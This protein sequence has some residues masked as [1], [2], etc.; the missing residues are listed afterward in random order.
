MN[1][2]HSHIIA[3]PFHAIFCHIANK[4]HVFDKHMPPEIDSSYRAAHNK[5]SKTNIDGTVRAESDMRSIEKM[6][7]MHYVPVNSASCFTKPHDN[8]FLQVGRG[9]I[10]WY[11]STS[12][13]N[14]AIKIRKVASA[15][16]ACPQ[17]ILIMGLSDWSYPKIQSALAV[18]GMYVCLIGTDSKLFER[19]F[20]SNNCF[21][22]FQTNFQVI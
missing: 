3:Y 18:V 8:S 2:P 16:N 19:C 21:K 4:N 20:P 22:S 12:F 5:L 7:A 11:A 17:G 6:F 13:S 10:T 9:Q 15:A 1:I 14:N